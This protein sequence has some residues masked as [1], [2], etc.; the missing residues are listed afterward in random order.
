MN[1]REH[2]ERWR[3]AEAAGREAEAEAALA[4]LFVRLPRLEPRPG[5]AAR[6]AAAAAAAAAAAEA[7]A[8]AVRR[9]WWWAAAAGIAL[10]AGILGALLVGVAGPAAGPVAGTLAGRLSLARLIDGLAAAVTA[11]ADWF[12][13]AA[14]LWG[15]IAD[16]GGALTTAA[17]TRPGMTAILVALALSGLAVRLLSDLIATERSWSHVALHG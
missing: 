16:V 12:S 3:A 10:A 15:P 6:V 5:F 8:A 2:L 7:A 9:P 11:C 14:G 4:A 1:E 13:G 17:G